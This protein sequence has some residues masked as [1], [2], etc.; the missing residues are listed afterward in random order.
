MKKLLLTL[1]GLY[2]TLCFLLYLFQEKILFHPQK[3]HKNYHYKFGPNA[4]EINVSTNDGKLLNGIL[5]KIENPKGLIFYLHGNAGS[6]KNWGSVAGLYNDLKYDVFILDYRGYGKSEGKITSQDQLFED[7]Q[8]V[9]NELKKLYK[10]KDII[11][12]GYSIGTGLAAKLASMNKPKRLILQAP[13]YSMTDL[14][15]QKL[16]IIPSFVLKY[17]LST[18]MYLKEC[19]MPLV[20]F[21]GDRD[22]V[23]YCGSSKKLKSEFKKGDKLFILEGQGHNGITDNLDYQNEIA[24]ILKD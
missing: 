12:L 2:I 18:H 23:I 13:Y 24:K 7:N 14:M 8:L 1:L 6:L 3:H 19:M 16:P 4:E 5:F 15:N 11:M 20:V 9:Y 17:K 10:E 21:H 22:R